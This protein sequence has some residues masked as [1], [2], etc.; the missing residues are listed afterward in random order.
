MERISPKIL[1]TGP[2]GCGKTTLIRKVVEL[3][4]C[5]ASGFYT[6]E[7]RGIDGKRIGF[8]VVTLNG[9]R[10]VLSREGLPGPRVGKYGVDLAFLEGVVLTGIEG[11][12]APLLVIDE[13]GKMECFSRPFVKAV[14]DLLRGP[15]AVLG[16]VALSGSPFIME[17]RTSPAIELIEVTLQNR[18]GL[19]EEIINRLR[20]AD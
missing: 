14:R 7:V 13:I 10:G 1:L 17:V 20:I 2:P 16:T 4:E 15:A 6:E 18:N 19:V 9:S 12:T 8:D 5:P 11:D 3:L